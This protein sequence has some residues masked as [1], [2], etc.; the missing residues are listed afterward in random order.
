MSINFQTF[1]IIIQI[2][3]ELQFQVGANGEDG[4]GK[5]ISENIRRDVEKA[6]VGERETGKGII[7]KGEAEDV[8]GSVLCFQ[9]S[10]PI[11]LM[12]FYQCD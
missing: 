7:R 8:E 5:K 11:R 1:S 12:F 9:M 10:L 6:G 2:Q 4:N 3:R